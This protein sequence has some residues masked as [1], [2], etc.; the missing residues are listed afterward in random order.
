MV[1][2]EEAWTAMATDLASTATTVKIYEA[3]SAKMK[4]GANFFF[5]HF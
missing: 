5:F 1:K 3:M 2:E 4:E